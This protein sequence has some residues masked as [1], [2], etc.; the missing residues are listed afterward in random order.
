[1]FKSAEP[2]DRSVTTGLSIAAVMALLLTLATAEAAAGQEIH[3][4]RISG[5]SGNPE[6]SS[7]SGIGAATA[8]TLPN[9]F[10]LR[11]AWETASTSLVREGYACGRSGSGSLNCSVE[12]GLHNKSRRSGLSVTLNADLA[13]WDR[14]RLSAGVGPHFTKVSIDA[15]SES[16]RTDPPFLYR[17]KWWPGG[18][19][20]RTRAPETLQLGA[21]LG[22]EVRIQPVTTLPL[23]ISAGWDSK[24]VSMDGCITSNH[25]VYAPYCGW[26]RFDEIRLGIGW[27]F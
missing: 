21:V 12:T 26:Q 18:T 14:V 20:P 27:V 9:G 22:G 7:Y 11:V 23:F 5:R 4:F 25:T 8:L 17:G 10:R 16:G 2:E 15:T 13:P 24:L 6:F 3:L 19:I 1:M